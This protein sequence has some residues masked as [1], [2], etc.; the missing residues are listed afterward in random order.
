VSKQR[1]IIV[2]DFDCDGV[3]DA[4]KVHRFLEKVDMKARSKF[5]IV[6]STFGVQERRGD[7]K[8]DFKRM[9]FRTG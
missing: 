4:A 2:L 8:P 9:K 6:H 1:A 7:G 3:M 5:D